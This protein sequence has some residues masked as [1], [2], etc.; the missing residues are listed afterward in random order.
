MFALIGNAGP[1]ELIWFLV[2]ALILVVP[3][4]FIFKKAGFS[5]RLSLL[6]IV[7]LVNIVML[8][9]LALTPWPIGGQKGIEMSHFKDLMV[10]RKTVVIV[11]VMA[12]II[13]LLNPPT[14]LQEVETHPYPNSKAVKYEQ[15][16]RID[17]ERLGLWIGAIVVGS[18]GLFYLTFPKSKK[19]G[20]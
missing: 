12:I 5:P 11:G 6:M 2:G 19:E 8:Y 13:C 18:G 17:T 20:E 4:W 15:V 7:P 3:F 10:N 14:Y 1:W 16:S 9:Y